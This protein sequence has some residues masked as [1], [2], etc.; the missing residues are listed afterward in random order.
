MYVCTRDKEARRHT[1]SRRELSSRTSFLAH[2]WLENGVAA[3]EF[4]H[5]N[6]KSRAAARAYL[7]KQPALQTRTSTG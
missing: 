7:G 3:R 4:R 1:G 5:W 6:E 2:A